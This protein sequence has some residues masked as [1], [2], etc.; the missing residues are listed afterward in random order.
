MYY[1]GKRRSL[2]QAKETGKKRSKKRDLFRGRCRS[3]AGCRG[4]GEEEAPPGRTRAAGRRG[5]SRR[6]PEGERGGGC[7]GWEAE[8]GALTF[9]GDSKADRP[10]KTKCSR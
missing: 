1:L 6:R 4:R 10:K 3:K 8:A 7:A 5:S 9:S 2:E